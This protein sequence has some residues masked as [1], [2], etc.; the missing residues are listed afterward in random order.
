MFCTRSRIYLRRCPLSLSDFL[1]LHQGLFLQ[2]PTS[3]GLSCSVSLLATNGCLHWVENSFLYRL[4]LKDLLLG[5]KFF[6]WDS[7]FFQHLPTSLPCPQVSTFSSKRP[8][9]RCVITLLKLLWLFPSG[10]TSS[11]FLVFRRLPVMFLG[12]V[13]FACTLR[14]FGEVLESVGYRPSSVLCNS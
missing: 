13:F 14:G 6:S 12:I 7:F 2:L 5:I 10:Q 4:L 9:V 3:L 8:C 11:L 1:C